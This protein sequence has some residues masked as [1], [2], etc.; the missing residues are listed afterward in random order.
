MIQLP[1]RENE[2]EN[3]REKVP[4]SEE[5]NN[6]V[7][8]KKIPVSE[9]RDSSLLGRR[10]AKEQ[11]GDLKASRRRTSY[12]SRLNT[13]LLWPSRG[14]HSRRPNLVVNGGCGEH[15]VQA[16]FYSRPSSG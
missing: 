7:E 9:E 2:F 3:V 8:K 5:R 10:S 14:L 13:N 15:L 11:S 1:E 6:D 12:V 4:V 16:I